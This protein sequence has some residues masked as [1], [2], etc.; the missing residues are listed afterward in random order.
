MVRTKGRLLSSR[1]ASFLSRVITCTR[2]NG[3][4]PIAA[5]LGIDPNRAI[6][7][8]R[9][10]GSGLIT[11]RILVTNIVGD[12]AADLVHFLDSPGKEGYTAGA[13]CHLLQGA[14]GTALLFLAQYAN[15]V[16][17][18]S[19]FLLQAKNSLLERFAAGIVLAV[20]YNK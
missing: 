1:R 9:L 14:P 17:G 18:R 2:P 12:G 11:D 4:L 13:G 7:G 20:S 5:R 8:Y 3:E 6:A 16:N 10:G 19:I 15:R